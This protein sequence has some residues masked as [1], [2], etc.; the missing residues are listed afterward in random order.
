MPVFQ[1]EKRLHNVFCPTSL[2]L[3]YAWPHASN[4]CKHSSSIWHPCCCIGIP[5]VAC[6]CLAGVPAAACNLDV[7]GV[8]LLLSNLL[9]LMF[10]LLLASL[11]S[12]YFLVRLLL[13]M[14]VL[15]QAF[16][17]VCRPAACFCPKRYC[18]SWWPYCCWPLASLLLLASVER[19]LL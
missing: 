10:L 18:C 13:F 12:L 9:M 11:W 4:N 8:F 17:L 1:S 5:I 2:L 19:L 6:P 15:L 7:E 3:L 14:C 16:L